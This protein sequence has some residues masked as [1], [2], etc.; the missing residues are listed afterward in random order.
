MY[1]GIR[2][3]YVRFVVELLGATDAH[4]VLAMMVEQGI[5]H[6]VSYYV[7]N[8]VRWHGNVSGH[9][10][11]WV[12][13]TDMNSLLEMAMLRADVKDGMLQNRA[14]AVGNEY[15]ICQAR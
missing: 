5:T 3:D 4:K 11:F 6:R 15:I 2:E 10:A 7:Q 13:N 1:Q 14:V 12:N 9:Q 8:G